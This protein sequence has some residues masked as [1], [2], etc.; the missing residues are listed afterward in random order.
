MS[1]NFN[2]HLGFVVEQVS[3][4]GIL[5]NLDVLT[6]EKTR[7]LTPLSTLTDKFL[8]KLKLEP[9][10]SIQ[11]VFC[12]SCARIRLASTYYIEKKP[13]LKNLPGSQKFTNNQYIQHP[14]K[15]SLKPSDSI[16]AFR[17]MVGNTK[18]VFTMLTFWFCT[19]CAARNFSHVLT[20]QPNFLVLSRPTNKSKYV[21]YHKSTISNSI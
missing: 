4:L 9:C 5:E 19:N 2:S 16:S 21:L 3:S 6:L 14:L 20:L 13:R 18:R 15:R 11:R 17:S 1:S 8:Q 7:T 12:F 10:E